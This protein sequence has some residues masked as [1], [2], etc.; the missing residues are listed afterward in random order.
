[1]FLN[2]TQYMEFETKYF[3]IVYDKSLEEDALLL[4]EKSDLIA[5]KV[6]NLFD[7][8]PEKKITILILNNEIENA[9]ADMYRIV[10]YPNVPD[11]QI[12]EP[13]YIDWIEY[14]FAHELTHAVLN[15]LFPFKIGSLYPTLVPRW[16]HEGTAV[17]IESSITEGCGRGCSTLFKNIPKSFSK[18]DFNTLNYSHSAQYY[19]GYSLLNFHKS[20]YGKRDLFGNIA[21]RA[22]SV[23]LNNLKH[24]TKVESAKQ[25]LKEWNDSVTKSNLIGEIYI[26]SCNNIAFLKKDGNNIIYNDGWYVRKLNIESGKKKRY[27]PEN[28]IYFS[29]GDRDIS[30]KLVPDNSK[31]EIGKKHQKHYVTVAYE[32]N[33]YLNIES[34]KIVMKDESRYISVTRKN[35]REKLS[36]DNREIISY[37]KNL[38]FFNVLSIDKK[39]YFLAKPRY[40]S[41]SYIYA[42]EENRE[43]KKYE[44]RIVKICQALSMSKDRSSIYFTSNREDKIGIFEYDTK[45][46]KIYL[47]S[48][49]DTALDPIRIDDKI[50]FLQ[51]SEGCKNIYR[52]DA[53]RKRETIEVL[54][55][56]LKVKNRNV[57][58]NILSKPYRD[59]HILSVRSDIDLIN[60]KAKII[61]ENE[62]ESKFYGITFNLNP[63]FG[64]YLGNRMSN[65]NFE[66]SL[67]ECHF[68]L[69][70]LFGLRRYLYNPGI[71]LENKLQ[72]DIKEI[73]FNSIPKIALTNLGLLKFTSDI[74][75]CTKLL[76]NFSTYY[77]DIGTKFKNLSLRKIVSNKPLSKV[78]VNIFSDTIYFDIPSSK[79]FL[80]ATLS[81]KFNIPTYVSISPEKVFNLNGIDSRLRFTSIIDERH[82]AIGIINLDLK[83]KFKIYHFYEFAVKIINRI[84]ISDKGYSY[85]FM[86][87]ILNIDL[88]N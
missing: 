51:Y 49:S 69:N 19:L 59:V 1:M 82:K 75:I 72:I 39:M 3:K 5:E 9:Y 37:D 47:I 66:Y 8:V 64:I 34:P 56:E 27:S 25:L 10:I 40:E 53:T 31:M 43:E 74:Y 23:E 78:A 35:G 41:G 62:L 83:L 26:K 44:K 55:E 14:V 17:E 6:F 18:L 57:T 61:Y 54:N 77:I 73:N 36:I 38:I 22:K 68:N 88:F 67:K 45:E 32:G 60:K 12:V 2:F 33:R 65:I 15:R 11:P 4:Y 58:K 50:Y 20:R 84:T 63:A 52:I 46:K 79:T 81:F 42:I 71:E 29:P 7:I 28:L 48:E 16:M 80:V 85:S 24:F 76:S 70:T 86:I 13:N 30:V 87:P 21:K